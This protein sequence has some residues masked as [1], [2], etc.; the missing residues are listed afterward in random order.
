M[1]NT[2]QV[3]SAIATHLISFT[4]YNSYRHS[5]S[6]NIETFDDLA[7]EL[8]N[9]GIFTSRKKPWTADLPLN[10]HPAAFRISAYCMPG[11]AG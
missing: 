9:V 11:W 8:N 1:D 10:Y 3:F 2:L 7:E 6:R 5:N 4:T